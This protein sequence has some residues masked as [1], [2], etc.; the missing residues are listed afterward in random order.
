MTHTQEKALRPAQHVGKPACRFAAPRPFA[1][2]QSLFD[3]LIPLIPPG[4]QSC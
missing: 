1:T 4:L 3:P 2:L